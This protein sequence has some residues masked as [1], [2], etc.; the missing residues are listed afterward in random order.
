MKI[1]KKKKLLKAVL[2]DRDGTLNDDTGYIS[3]PEDLHLY[4]EVPGALKKLQD[5]GYLLI[6]VSNQSGVARGYFG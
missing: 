6:I 5:A 4:P 1:V 2:L 3:N